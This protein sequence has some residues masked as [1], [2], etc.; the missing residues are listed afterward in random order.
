MKKL[1][2]S[3]VSQW[4]DLWKLLFFLYLPISLLFLGLGV[5]SRV[6]QAMSL[7]ILMQDVVA[8]GRLPTLAG[9]VS[10]MGNL[11][12]S[13]SLTVCCLTLII[14]Q[15]RSLGFT[16]TKRF[17]LQAG[18]V[19]SILLF[20]DTFLFHTDLAL[21]YFGIKKEEV[22]LTYVVMGFLFVVSN[23]REILS[24]E[25]ILLMFALIMFGASI[26]VDALPVGNEAAQY[27]LYKIEL[28]M[29][30]GFKFAGIATWLIYFGR[31][32]IQQIE[33]IQE[34]RRSV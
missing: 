18:I 11:L 21:L 15:R 2:I 12:W 27:Y 16:G 17:L 26:F 34:T 31:Y 6:D 13:A 4:Q 3:V 19:T 25:Y 33:A 1:S 28:L 23:R 7:E 5:W 32:A 8:T 9:L 30:D 20:D 29:E 22:I 24:S 14:L 10:Q